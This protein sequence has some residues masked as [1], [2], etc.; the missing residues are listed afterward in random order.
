MIQIRTE[1]GYH[2]TDLKNGE[3][4]QVGL[5]GGVLIKGV[6][7]RGN[8]AMLIENFKNCL[9]KIEYDCPFLFPL[10]NQTETLIYND[11]EFKYSHWKEKRGNHNFST[12]DVYRLKEFSAFEIVGKIDDLGLNISEN[13]TSEI[14]IGIESECNKILTFLNEKINFISRR[15]INLALNK[16]LS[17]RI[18]VGLDGNPPQ[19]FYYLVIPYN[20]TVD[21]SLTEEMDNINPQELRQYLNEKS[22]LK[23]YYADNQFDVINKSLSFIDAIFKLT[24]DFAFYVN[25]RPESISKLREELI[26]DLFLIPI[27][28]HDYSAE[29]EAYIYDGKLDYRIANYNNKYEFI[30][31]EFKIWSGIPSF[32][33]CYIQIT[34]KHSTGNE[35]ELYLIMINKTNKNVNDIY[36]QMVDELSR[37]EN[38]VNTI[39]SNISLSKAQL[40]SRHLIQVKGYEVPLVV[41][42]INAFHQKV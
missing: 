16:I 30:S 7:T 19:A 14:I 12:L 26:R 25:E 17:F 23:R 37:K 6:Y 13:K 11:K 28:M 36:N 21:L 2:I 31:G 38:Y 4:Y 27:K 22:Q 5:D 42:V 35:T 18:T 9:F 15:P 8:L 20:G 24:H 32:N 33:E 3:E 41:G 40:F 10:E 1:R 34:E 39:S 29:A